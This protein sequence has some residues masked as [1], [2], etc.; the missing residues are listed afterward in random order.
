MNRPTEVLV[1]L[2]SQEQARPRL[3]G[4]CTC[5]GCF[6]K[7]TSFQLAKKT[8]NAKMFAIY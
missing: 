6:L 5:L 8:V 7:I 2:N 4:H 3:S 1:Y